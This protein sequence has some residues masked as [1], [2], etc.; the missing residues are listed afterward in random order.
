MFYRIAFV[1]ALLVAPVH[2]SAQ[3]FEV[4]SGPGVTGSQQDTVTNGLTESFRYFERAFGYQFNGPANVYMS[5][6]PRFL[7]TAMVRERKISNWLAEA[8]RAWTSNRENEAAFQHLLM[9]TSGSA[10]RNGTRDVQRMLAHEAFHLIQYELVGAKSRSC[11]DQERVSVVG[12]TWLMEGAAEYAMYRYESD[13][14][15]RNLRSM[16]NRSEA[17][18][19]QYRGS[20]ATLETGDA[21]YAAG[22]AYDIGAFA[23]HMLVEIAGP[24]SVPQFYLA[25][26]RSGNWKRAFESAFGLSVDAFYARFDEI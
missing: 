13:V 15:G 14:H 16:L 24:S 17:S 18:A 20:L 3:A 21:F 4:H 2:L 26:R 19:Q 5:S 11:C 9:R 23:T 6:D 8:T 7:A 25:L 1:I 22:N 12:P 10:F